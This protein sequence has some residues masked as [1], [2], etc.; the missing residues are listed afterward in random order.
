MKNF[1]SLDIDLV[2]KEGTPI[3]FDVCSGN[4]RKKSIASSWEVQ[5]DKSILDSHKLLTFSIR[6]PNTDG[7][8]LAQIA[9]AET[10]NGLKVFRNFFT[11]LKFA[12]DAKSNDGSLE[13][14]YELGE[15][16]VWPH[17]NPVLTELCTALAQELTN[18]KELTEFEDGLEFAMLRQLEIIRLQFEYFT[19]PLYNDLDEEKVQIPPYGELEDQIE[20]L[21]DKLVEL[22]KKEET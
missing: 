13:A 21:S 8:N 14:F 4:I 12:T 9:T 11:H 5:F 3:A 17:P 18:I 1:G 15:T 19:N 20:E 6:L 22:C 7:K 16:A 10:T 2:D